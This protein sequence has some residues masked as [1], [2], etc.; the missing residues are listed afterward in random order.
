MIF[1]Y[2][3]EIDNSNYHLANILAL[4]ICDGKN[5][6][7]VKKEHNANLWKVVNKSVVEAADR[8]KNESGCKEDTVTVGYLIERG[9]LDT[10]VNPITKEIIS[11]DSYVDY[12]SNEFIIV[13]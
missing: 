12:R 10:V 2:I 3:L 1:Q 4:G 5:L 13:N 9:Y 6:F 11:N 8:C 7:Y